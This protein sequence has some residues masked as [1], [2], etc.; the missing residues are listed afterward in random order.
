MDPSINCVPASN[1]G[2]ATNSLIYFKVWTQIE[3]VKIRSHI[4]NYST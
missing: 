3:Q 2:K 1:G 4:D